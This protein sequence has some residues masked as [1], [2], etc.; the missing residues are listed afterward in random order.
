MATLLAHHFKAQ[1]VAIII[2]STKG[3]NLMSTDTSE[4]FEL[5]AQ[6]AR[7][8]GYTLHTCEVRA[9]STAQGI[10]T[11]SK[12][13]NAQQSCWATIFREMNVISN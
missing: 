1:P 9:E 10:V 13:K 12:E 2:D 3:T 8:L 4:L 5:A 11:A 6:E 7:S